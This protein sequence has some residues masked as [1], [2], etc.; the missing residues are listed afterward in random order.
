MNQRTS[1]STSSSSAVAVS[2]GTS[3]FALLTVVF[4]AAKVMGFNDMS[5]FMV[6][7]PIW[8]SVLV[9]VCTMLLIFCGAF[10]Y[11]TILEVRRVNILKKSNKMKNKVDKK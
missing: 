9:A 1:S 2:G 10:I 11:H 8:G 7:S 6:F 4:A 5:W 3:L